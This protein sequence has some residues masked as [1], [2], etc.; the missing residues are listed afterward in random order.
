[1]QIGLNVWIHGDLFLIIVFFLG[2]SLISW[3]A[4]KQQTFSRSSSEAGY[5]DCFM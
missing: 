4:K 5:R 3:K 1:M 2:S